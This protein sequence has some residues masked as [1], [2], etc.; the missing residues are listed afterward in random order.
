MAYAPYVFFP[1]YIHPFGW[2]DS[3]E[4]EDSN[5]SAEIKIGIVGE[6]KSGKSSFINAIM[7]YVRV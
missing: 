5:E 3:S 7:R 1:G 6:A 4:P 2:K